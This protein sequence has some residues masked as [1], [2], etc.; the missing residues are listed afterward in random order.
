MTY[1]VNENF[2]KCALQSN[3]QIN[4]I[5]IQ[6]VGHVLP[7]PILGALHHHYIRI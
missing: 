4:A 3:D 6:T 5:T 2:I 1:I 7:L